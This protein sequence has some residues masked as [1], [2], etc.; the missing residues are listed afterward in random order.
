MGSERGR[1]RKGDGDVE[2]RE[3]WVKGEGGREGSVTFSKLCWC[4]WKTFSCRSVGAKG[5]TSLILTG[6][7]NMYAHVYESACTL[8]MY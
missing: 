7:M 4:P 1:K 3:K 2:G 5:R 6:F 8:Y